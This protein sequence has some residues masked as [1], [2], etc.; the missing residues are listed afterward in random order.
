MYNTICRNTNDSTINLDEKAATSSRRHSRHLDTPLRPPKVFDNGGDRLS[1][2]DNDSSD[3]DNEV[4]FDASGWS[5]EEI[6]GEKKR[7]SKRLSG[8]H[9]GSAGGLV[10]SISPAS[11][12]KSKAPLN[13]SIAEEEEDNEAQHAAKRVWEIDESFV[14]KERAAEWLGQRNSFNAKALTYYMDYLEC[15]G[16]RLDD[17]FRKLC[18]RLY[19]KAEAQQIDRVLEAFARRYWSCNPQSIF[20]NADSVYAVAYSLLLL[21]TDLHVVQGNHVRMTRSAFVRNTI[22]T[23]K[24][25]SPETPHSFSKAWENDMEI[26]LKELYSSVKNKQILQPVSNLSQIVGNDGSTS[27]PE[28]RT[29]LLGG[30]KVVDFRRSVN[31]MMARKTIT[32]HQ[33]SII[34]I[35]DHAIPTA[36]LSPTSIAGSPS[37]CSFDASMPVCASPTMAQQ[38]DVQLV[39][40]APHQ[41]P[42]F[43][44]GFLMRKHLLE[45]GS[46]KAKHRDWKEC[47]VVVS[48]GELKMFGAL[49]GSNSISSNAS[50]I[51]S[52]HASL[53][54]G[55]AGAS[56]DN[57]EGAK[58]ESK[59][60][61]L[62]MP[63]LGTIPLN[64]S[65]SNILPPPGYNRQRPHV[66]AIQQ[67][68]GGVYLFQ[69]TSAEH[70]ND[71]VCTCNYWAARR[72]KDPL[73]GGVS[74]MEYGWGACLDDV[75]LD[76]DGGDGCG[77]YLDDPDT[78][79]I[80]DWQP[81]APPTVSSTLT[82]EDQ[83]VAL[84]KHLRALAAEIN[85]HREL[86]RKILVKFTSKSA[87]HDKVIANWEARSTYLLHEIIKYQ[88][89]CD[90]LEKSAW[91]RSR[92]ELPLI[93]LSIPFEYESEAIDLLGEIERELSPTG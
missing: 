14:A 26:Y 28:R 10:L 73:S 22:S 62:T 34:S 38:R 78:V 71:W 74:N 60:G 68:N 54:E 29:S 50:G 16:M 88:N 20:G 48:Q 49:S 40:H 85:E 72:S 80:Y 9:F 90:I 31:S 8:G 56:S 21:N 93:L 47:F 89:Y 61:G 77:N 45:T 43:Q 19:F 2:A 83:I 36:S 55:L 86:K 1:D 44:E 13:M 33:N 87:N 79:C 84:R 32:A 53:A 17:A 92:Q 81:P 91:Q 39:D 59:L 52:N 65:L 30:K 70:L 27:M 58:R 3:S 24:Q 7:L 75:I 63:L 23:I 18:T 42:Y 6:E 35:D 12:Y 5:Q 15:A 82:E 25:Q 37:R 46:Q 51:N 76:L 57:G 64:H 66:F 67:P 41:P 69:T 11:E 4:F